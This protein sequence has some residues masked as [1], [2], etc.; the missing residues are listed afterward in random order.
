LRI[1]NKEG[2]KTFQDIAQ[3][4]EKLG[5]LEQRLENTMFMMALHIYTTF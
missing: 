3:L 5:G 1:G 2:M 4:S